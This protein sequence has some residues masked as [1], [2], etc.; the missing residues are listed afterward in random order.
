MFFYEDRDTYGSNAIEAMSNSLDRMAIAEM[1]ERQELRQEKKEIPIIVELLR[2]I[3]RELEK[4]GKNT[5]EK[6]DD[7]LRELADIKNDARLHHLS[8]QSKK[9]GPDKK[10]FELE[11]LIQGRC[12][13]K[14]IPLSIFEVERARVNSTF[15]T[16]SQGIKAHAAAVISNL[17]KCLWQWLLS[18][19]KEMKENVDANFEAFK[20]EAQEIRGYLKN[21]ESESES[22][23]NKLS[24]SFK[25][26][27]NMFFYDDRKKDDIMQQDW[28]LMCTTLDRMA[29][30][31]MQER[32][33][34]LKKEIPIIVDLLR[35]I[36][37]ELEKLG[38]NTKEKTDDMLKELADIKNDARLHH[39]SLQSKK[40]GLDK[41]FVELEELIQ[42]C[43]TIKK[44]PLSIFEGSKE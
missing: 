8:L 1:Q 21:A 17:K 39:L 34:P 38:K 41:K 24:S 31:K 18:D 28:A 14:K 7:M 3:R 11:E 22:M 44:I 25:R 27:K 2:T 40:A 26:L 13:I 19:I 15:T 5:K 43:C 30:E 32:Q 9:A 4:L 20:K 10:F 6:T 36:R 33:R 12:T 29:V 35:T 37:R 23:E 16:Q 42:G